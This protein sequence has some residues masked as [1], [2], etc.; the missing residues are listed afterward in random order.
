MK[1][2]GFPK[3][4]AKHT[5]EPMVTPKKWFGKRKLNKPKQLETAIFI[6]SNNLLRNLRRALKM[7]RHYGAYGSQGNADEFI[8]KNKKVMVVKLGIGAPLTAT[9]AEEL[10]FYGI[11]NFIILGSSG[12][13][14]KD[15]GINEIVLCTKSVRDEGT[16]HHYVK[17]SLFAYPDKL[18]SKRL[19]LAITKAGFKF[20]KA[21]SWTI[22]AP[23]RETY[24]EVMH[25]R[26]MG[27]VSVEMEA[28]ALFTVAKLFKRRASAAFFISDILDEERDGTVESRKL[29]YKKMAK[30]AEALFS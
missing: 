17:S 5:L 12:S 3:I 11:K 7:K 26:K 24:N 10:I 18:L 8:S 16:S 13:L 2:S 19:A 23:Y 15:V 20:R 21:P 1:Y 4:G 22:D 14:S 27:I 30:I 29:G 6:Y 28:A 25:Y 9:V